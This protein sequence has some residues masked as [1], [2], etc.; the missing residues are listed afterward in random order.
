M[1]MVECRRKRPEVGD[2]I[3]C[4]REGLIRAEVSGVLGA[5][6]GSRLV[7]KDMKFRVGGLLHDGT[8]WFS[9]GEC[10]RVLRKVEDGKT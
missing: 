8:W 6:G 2:I 7:V 5:A 9:Q 10:C 4:K 3:T 1:R